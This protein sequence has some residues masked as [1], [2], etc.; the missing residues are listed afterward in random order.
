MAVVTKTFT[1]VSGTEGYVG[2]PAT[3]NISMVHDTSVGNPPG[4]L[5]AGTGNK[6]I[7]AAESYWEYSGTWESLG[8]P[9]GGT[10]TSVRLMGASTRC[11]TRTSHANS[12]FLGPYRIHAEGGSQIGVLWPGRNA[13]SQETGWTNTPAQAPVAIPS[14]SQPSNAT[15]LIRL[16][17][18]IGTSSG[19]GSANVQMHDDQVSL[20]ITYTEPPSEIPISASDSVTISVVETAGNA[21][22]VIAADISSLEVVDSGTIANSSAAN[23]TP[24]IGVSESENV[25]VIL[26]TTDA[27]TMSVAESEVIFSALV[28]SDTAGLVASDSSSGFIASTAA[29]STSLSVLDISN[30]ASE[31][32]GTET[33]TIGISETASILVTSSA[34]DSTTL[35]ISESTAIFVAQDS[36]DGITIVAADSS[37][38]AKNLVSTDINSLAL[39]ESSGIYV[40]LSTLDELNVTASEN[41]GGNNTTQ[42]SDSLAIGLVDNGEV[43]NYPPGTDLVTLGVSETSAVMVSG[44][45]HKAGSDNG[46]LSLNETTTINVSIT[47]SDSSP[48]GVSE[49]T[50][51]QN[52]VTSSDASE[53]GVI[54]ARDINSALIRSD[55]LTLGLTDESSVQV[56]EEEEEIPPARPI[57]TILSVSASDNLEITVTETVFNSAGLQIVVYQEGQWVEG[58]PVVFKNGEWVECDLVI[59]RNEN[60]R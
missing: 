30:V 32:P 50:T 48:V 10:V 1:F 34:D 26:N 20:E 24:G 13:T 9:A 4:S 42:A 28:S 33:A 38:L 7:A 27:L 36:S 47:T 46:T 41:T 53:F 23:D 25:V 55:A 3:A 45:E 12:T 22:T 59:Y 11:S 51:G 16:A 49:A 29:D 5:R 37:A 31:Q 35:S 58:Q 17:D 15:V 57:D 40:T 56:F 21:A 52:T 8:V 54:E 39:S 44:D 18:T 60:W 2:V 6:N 43:A 14:N 19:G